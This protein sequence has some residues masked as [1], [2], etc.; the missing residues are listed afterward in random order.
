MNWFGFHHNPPMPPLAHN[1]W[2]PRLAAFVLAALAAGSAVY[3]ALKWPAS[4]PA[5]TL[6]SPPAQRYAGP[7]PA[8]LARALGASPAS[9]APAVTQPA[10]AAAAASSRLTLVGVVANTRSGGTALISVDGKPA[11]PFR[12]GALVEGEWTLQSVAQ[13][14][15]VLSSRAGSQGGQGGEGA[16]TLELPVLKS[17]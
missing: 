2:W 16:F 9:A 13:R 15:A 4:Q 12:V 5:T 17:R 11:R 1:V 14:R 6:Q 3:W 8:V 7:D 10:M